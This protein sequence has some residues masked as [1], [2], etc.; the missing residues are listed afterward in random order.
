MRH[1]LP[2][3][4]LACLLLS[5]SHPPTLTYLFPFADLNALSGTFGEL[6]SN[7]FHS[8][9]DVKTRGKVGI[10][11]RAIANGYVYRLRTGPRG[12]GTAIYLRHPNGQ[13][14]VYAHLLRMKPELE[15]YHQAQQ[16]AHRQAATNS[17]PAASRFP[18]KLGEIIGYSGNSGSSLGPHLHFEIRD[19]QERILNPLFHYRDQIGDSRPPIIQRMA[20]QPIDHRS[21][22][23][24]QHQMR[25]YRV[26]GQAPSYEL[27][28][29]IHVRGPVGLAYQAYDLLDAAGNHCGVNYADLYLDDSLLYRFALDT[30]AFRETR[31]LN[32]HLDYGYLLAT[33]VRLQRAY[34]PVG[35]HLSAHRSAVGAGIIEL[36]DD[37]LHQ[38][39]LSLRDLHG[40]QTEL[41]GYL[42]RDTAYAPFAETPRP[43][44]E[45]TVSYEVEPNLLKLKVKGP[46]EH[47]LSQGLI[48]DNEFGHRRRWLPAYLA[49]NEA[50]FLLP[51]DRYDYPRRIRDDS[52]LVAVE[53]PLVEEIHPDRNN[54]AELGELQAFFPYDA[55]FRPIHLTLSREP[56]EPGMLSDIYHIGQPS[57]PV[58]RD[59]VVSLTPNTPRPGMM[60]AYWDGQEW[61]FAGAEQGPDGSVRASVNDFG[62]FCLMADSTAPEL[63]AINFGPGGYIGPSSQLILRLRDE[64]SGIDYESIDGYLG[65]QWIC[66]EYDWKR[67][68]IVA[69]MSRYEIPAGKQPLRVQVRDGAGNVAEVAYELRF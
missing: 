27:R 2:W 37:S 31:Y 1:T 39:R 12:F 52:G 25:T 24:G 14:S 18:V 7:H 38:F 33:D 60:V 67:A 4:L 8:G 34:R 16:Q 3:L 6:R 66:F 5:G 22:I 56:G 50:V 55:V 57:E 54:L 36:Q 30:F 49:D 63:R 28:E 41:K 29:T 13:S 68:R 47:L 61:D 15:A 10:P 59:Y 58:F 64:F 43:L 17:Y 19:P 11:I 40:N 32:L 53:V 48:Y 45:P 65:E 69:E 42:Q 23:E 9:I 62:A 35:N 20:V 44:A 21:R 26:Y 51:L 46:P